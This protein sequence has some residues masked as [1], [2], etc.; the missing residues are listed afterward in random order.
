MLV[1]LD[2]GILFRLLEPSDPHH[3]SIR[4]ALRTPRGRGDTPVTSAQNADA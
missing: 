2:T 3:A 4:V 1:L